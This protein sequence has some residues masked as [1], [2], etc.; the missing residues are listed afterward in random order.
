MPIR[1]EQPVLL[2]P[3][4]LHPIAEQ[5]TRQYHTPD[6]KSAR[7]PS[8]RRPIN[9]TSA[10][11]VRVNPET[12]KENLGR[13][14]NKI[15][16]VPSRSPFQERRPSHSTPDTEK[17][18]KIG[19]AAYASLCG[20]SVHKSAEKDY[21]RNI[22]T[23]TRDKSQVPSS[24]QPVL[25]SRD[26]LGHLQMD[27]DALANANAQKPTINSLFSKLGNLSEKI[28]HVK[29]QKHG[30]EARNYFKNQ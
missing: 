20:K 16:G 13:K 6:P 22:V 15:I 10:N 12:S 9:E 17:A 1:A 8:L 27:S 2:Q 29:T 30:L 28:Q 4:T 11:K 21:K 24:N 14:E 25:I 18:K 26:P 3:N 7:P 19:D 23:H 5:S